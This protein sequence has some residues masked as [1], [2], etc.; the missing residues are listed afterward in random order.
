MKHIKKQMMF[1]SDDLDLQRIDVTVGDCSMTK[2]R[3]IHYDENH[4]VLSVKEH[5]DIPDWFIRDIKIN[6]L[7]N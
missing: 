2:W 7:L 3:E 5:K 6:S 4:E 1:T